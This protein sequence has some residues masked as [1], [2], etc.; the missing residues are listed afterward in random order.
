MTTSANKNHTPALAVPEKDC[1]F[2]SSFEAK[3]RNDGFKSPCGSEI[4]PI[5]QLVSSI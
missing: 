3:P 2:A 1:N 4:G 5:A